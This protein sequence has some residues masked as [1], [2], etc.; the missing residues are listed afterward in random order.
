[1]SLTSHLKDKNS[2]VLQFFE[3][4]FHLADFIKNENNKLKSLSTILPENQTDY[5]WSHTGHITEYLLAI[6]MNL[7]F[8]LL[9]PMRYLEHYNLE[10]YKQIKGYNINKKHLSGEHFEG[11]V[12]KTL[13]HLSCFESDLRSKPNPNYNAY[14]KYQLPSNCVNDLKRLYQESI[15]TI[16]LFNNNDNDFI[17]N[18]T[19]NENLTKLIGGADADLIFEDQK[20]GGCLLDLKT[21]KNARIEKSMLYQLFGYIALDNEN[22]FKF[23]KMGLYLTRQKEVVIYDLNQLLKD[24]SDLSSSQDLRIKFATHLFSSRFPNML[25]MKSKI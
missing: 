5:P 6:H 3:Q 25:T 24:Y 12:S 11:I 4:H 15:S 8:E 20:N 10:K 18:P 16:P 1:M 19:F 9:F 17:Y 14:I 22:E 21:T 23:S 2:P 7:P 13:Y